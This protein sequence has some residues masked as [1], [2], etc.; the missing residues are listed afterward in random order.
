M[1]KVI[2][3]LL[4]FTFIFQSCIPSLYPLYDDKTI[5]FDETLVGTWKG[6]DEKDVTWIITALPNKAYQLSVIDL[7]GEKRTF[8][9][10]LVKIGLS[11][12]VD[13]FP[14][15]E[16]GKSLIE[17]LTINFDENFYNAHWFPV[18]TFGKIV[19]RKNQFDLR[20]FDPDYLKKLIEQ[21]R[22]RIKHEKT[23]DDILLTASTKELQKFVAKYGDDSQLY[24]W[25]S[26][27]LN[28]ISTD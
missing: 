27:S 3:C 2:F 5:I 4:V 9:I 13:F 16:A 1:K 11:T 12:Y 28:K 26:M 6:K 25:T 23:A 17:T 22:I 15:P 21:K 10:H 19:I 14:D 18:H 7:T 24:G 8:R 20:M